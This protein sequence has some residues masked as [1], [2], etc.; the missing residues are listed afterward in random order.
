MPPTWQCGFAISIEDTRACHLIAKLT[1]RH[2]DDFDD[3]PA[4]QLAV[5]SRVG[6]GG[7]FDC[8]LFG[9]G[10]NPDSVPQ[11]ATHRHRRFGRVYVAALSRH[12]PSLFIHKQIPCTLPVLR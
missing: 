7:R 6:T 12:N 1:S 2:D 3:G 5:N 9:A 11:L 4:L 8:R 10:W